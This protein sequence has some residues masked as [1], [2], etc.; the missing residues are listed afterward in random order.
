VLTAL[1]LFDPNTA[2]SG[3]VRRSPRAMREIRV[4]L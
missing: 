2:P 3:T 4:W 1:A